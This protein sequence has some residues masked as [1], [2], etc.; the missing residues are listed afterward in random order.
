MSKAKPEAQP[1]Q[2]A[3]RGSE[4]APASPA[5]TGAHADWPKLWTEAG[6]VLVLYTLSAVALAWLFPPNGL[7]PLAFVCLVPWAVAT[8]RTHRAWLAHWLSFLV[9][10]GFFVAAL[11][12][13]LPVTAPGAIALGFY[14]A[15]Y[16]TL[17]AW[18]IRTGRRHGISPI[19]TLPVT[20]VACE[21]LRAIV[22]TGFPW[23]FVSHGLYAQLPLIQI[24]D[25]VGAYGVTFLC[26]LINGVLVEA[27]LRRWPAPG[28]PTS[29]W[30]LPAGAAFAVLLLA[31]TLAYG[32]FRLN[33]LDFEND[34]SL[35]GPR[36]AV[37]Q[38]DFPLS[39]TPPYGQPPQVILAAYLNL[40]AQAAQE[41]PDL[42]VFPESMWGAVQNLDFVEIDQ[43]TLDDEHADTWWYGNLCHQALAAFARGD[44]PAVNAELSRLER[45]STVKVALPRLPAEGGVEATV[46]VGSISIDQFPDETYPKVRRYN[47]A[48]VYDPDGTQ[49]RQRYDKCHLVPFGEFVPFRQAEFLGLDLHWLYLFLNRLSPFSDGGRIEYSSTPGSGFTTFDL[50]TAD[51]SYTFGVPI[52][53]EDAMPYVIREFT[54]EGSRRRVDFLLN[55]SND[56]WFLYSNELPQH[57][58]ICALRAVENRVGIARAVNTGISGFIDPNGRIYARV[59]D[60]QGRS[61]GRGVVGYELRHVYVDRRASFYG[62]TGDYL[63]GACLVLACLLWCG[64]VFERWILALTLKVRALLK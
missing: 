31:A 59:T 36:I 43:A 32:F 45:A 16:W 37:I 52:C 8:C 5:I 19:W 13:L 11:R 40:A 23:L 6:H 26:M 38:E 48:L 30:Q 33:E 7:W 64:A 3:R 17:A 42:I 28:A 39:S 53:Y 41:H 44:Y 27:A 58:A 56:A 25:L 46:V 55:I 51:E 20:W 21:F 14:L 61:V 9:G 2:P 50:E 34:P 18:A 49:R 47:S 4:P 12:W 15:I 1:R 60:A 62:R 10:W 54:W 22:L 35:R 24:C 63:A 57:L 29:R